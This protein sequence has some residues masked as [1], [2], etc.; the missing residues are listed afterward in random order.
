MSCTYNYKGKDLSEQELINTLAADKAIANKYVAQEQRGTNKREALY[1]FQQ[2]VKHLQK[3]MDVEVV[4]DY[5]VE[6]SRVLAASDPK[7]IKAGK[8]VILINPD[9]IFKSTAIHE[10]GHIFVDSLPGGHKNARVQRAYDQ[11]RGTAVFNQVKENYPEYKEDSEQFIK[12]V[13]T[14]AIGNTGAE[15]FESEM[16]KSKWNAFKEWFLDFMNRTFGLNRDEVL[17]LTK[18]LISDQVSKDISDRTISDYQQ[19][20]RFANKSEEM[21]ELEKEISSLDSLYEQITTRIFNAHKLDEPK[22][23]RDRQKRNNEI[24]SGVINYSTGLHTLMKETEVDPKDLE[25]L[26][27]TDKLITILKF[28]QWGEQRLAALDASLQ[29]ALDDPTTN[30][31]PELIRAYK[32]RNDIF[33]TLKEVQTIAEDVSKDGF[34]EDY[35]LVHK[36]LVDSGIADMN[37]LK[38]KIDAKILNVERAMFAEIMV[39]GSNQHLVEWRNKF[40]RQYDTIKPNEAKIPWVEK[41]MRENAEA[42]KK[43]AYDTYLKQAEESPGDIGNFMASLVTEKNLSSGE[44]QVASKMFD[45]ADMETADYSKNRANQMKAHYDK[46]VEYHGG[47]INREEM[48]KKFVEQT[49]DGSYFITKYQV[50]YLKEL[51]AL[52][53]DANDRD[54]SEEK[55]GK[56]EVA[57]NNIYFVEGNEAPQLLKGPNGEKVKVKGMFATYMVGNAPYQL[58]VATLIARQQMKDWKKVNQKVIQT[59]K[60]TRTVPADKWLNKEYDKLTEEEFKQLEIFKG[61]IKEADDL[62]Q[63]EESLI[64]RGASQEWLRLPGVTRTT[65][66][67]V[68]AGDMKNAAIDKVRDAFQKKEDEYDLGGTA[69]ADRNETIK[70]L[71]DINNKEMHKIPLRYRSKLPQG[72]QSLDI[73][74]ILLLNLEAAKNHKEKK[75]LEMQILVMADVMTNRLNPQ[76]KSGKSAIHSFSDIKDIRLFKSK[77]ELPNDVAKLLDMAENR[78]YGIKSKDAGEVAG[79][80]VQKA[81]STVLKYAGSV[82]LIG[83]FMNSIVNAT[84]GTVNNLIE[85]FGGETYT[86]KDWKKAGVKYWSDTK[87]LMDDMG[88]NVATS[89]TNLF[90]NL[91]ST[92]GSSQALDH[93]FEDNNRVKALFSMHSLRPIAQGGEHMMQ[94]KVMYAVMNNIKVLDKDGNFLNA[95]GKIVKDR[96]D[97]VSLDEVIEFH[98]EGSSDIRAKMPDWVGGTT[99]SPSASHGDILLETRNLVKKKIIDLHGNYDPE[100][101]SAAQREWWGKLLF[102]L[103]KWME[104]TTLRRYR[105]LQSALKSSEELTEADRF[106]SE[107]L[108]SYQEGYYVTA[109]RFIKNSIMPAMKSFNIELVKS[110]FKNMTTHEKANAKRFLA[111][112][113]MMV[114]ILLAYAAMGGM[115]DDPDDDT[116]LARFYLRRELAELSFYSNPAE[117]LKII[118]SPSAAINFTDKI[119]KLMGQSFSPT[120]DYKVGVNKGRNKLWVKF[121]KALPIGSQSEKD[122][123]A[124]LRFLQVMD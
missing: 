27:D 124:S 30:I 21:N 123:K 20:E 117:A 36:E 116:L 61:Y 6:S 93:G 3:K 18:E 10:F 110:D 40:G 60:G 72:E 2:K 101:Q 67:R 118:K 86:M 75:Q 25:K 58:P 34:S 38:T 11:L 19:E 15:I 79:V 44:I 77:S 95:E 108:K 63:G 54:L 26:N 47:E 53:R 23:F 76:T 78:L 82:S 83:N 50:E 91:F 1:N 74:T 28:V 90:N 51:Q 113:G 121:L 73:H 52:E 104:S 33:E 94:S 59:T 65:M 69:A 43:Q 5:E 17:A 32:N 8:P 92:L 46:F 70:V 109:V 68:I 64:E 29:N 56:V 119:T 41:K 62:S 4:L 107:D 98:K 103:K 31:T 105:G 39:E 22:N 102:F 71:A 42:I 16:D 99:F 122:F 24:R 35:L 12:E 120:E 100:I 13:V 84:T 37:G 97:A 88:S 96:K 112:M 66:S 87:G 115:D 57:A 7:T 111:E 85:A 9:R 49:E 106:Y 55:Y 45:R 81:T 80:N 48:Y 14:T 89:R 114:T